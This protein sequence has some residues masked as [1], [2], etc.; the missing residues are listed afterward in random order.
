VASR[1][2]VLAFPDEQGAGGTGQGIRIA[3]GL[4]IPVWQFNRFSTIPPVEQVL[5]EVLM[6]LSQKESL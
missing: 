3:K 4:G 2:L 1:D 5:A 6:L